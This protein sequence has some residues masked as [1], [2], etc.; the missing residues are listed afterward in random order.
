MQILPLLIPVLQ[1]PH[2]LATEIIYHT[3]FSSPSFELTLLQVYSWLLP[4]AAETRGTALK[5]KFKF[6]LNKQ[7]P[8]C[9]TLNI[10]VL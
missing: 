8:Y 9:L 6:L 10:T 1:V 3:L 5:F 2:S 7:N 4:P